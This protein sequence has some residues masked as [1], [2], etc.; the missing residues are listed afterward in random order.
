V[1]D[2]KNRRR[3]RIDEYAGEFKNAVYTPLD[4][5]ASHNALWDHKAD[6]AFPSATQNE[7]CEFL[8]LRTAKG[9]ATEHDQENNDD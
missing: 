7:I 2:L 4:A 6:C 9:R 3:G 8:A 5:R 1:L